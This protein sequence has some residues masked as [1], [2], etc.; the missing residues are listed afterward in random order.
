MDA[1]PDDYYYDQSFRE[2][3]DIEERLSLDDIIDSDNLNIDLIRKFAKIVD[4]RFE[5][6]NDTIDHLLS[7]IDKLE[8]VNKKLASQLNDI[9]RKDSAKNIKIE[10]DDVS[11]DSFVVPVRVNGDVAI[12]QQKLTEFLQTHK[13]IRILMLSVYYRG[14]PWWINLVVDGYND[15]LIAGRVSSNTET[16]SFMR[17]QIIGF[18][19]C[20][21]EYISSIEANGYQSKQSV[22]VGDTVQCEVT[23]STGE[24][25]NRTITIVP[26]TYKYIYNGVSRDGASGPIRKATYEIDVDNGEI[27]NE[28]LVGKSLLNRHVGD[29]VVVHGK[30]SHEFRYKIK[31]IG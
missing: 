13:Y 10:T 14:K 3:M 6:Q 28:S 15:H 19:E 18:S 8:Y 26:A 16:H 30:N 31:R 12:N 25:I 23:M 29:V 24:I 9:K 7:R 2:L 4:A 27:S 5:E 22:D 21:K 1:Q 17:D 20:S 11:T